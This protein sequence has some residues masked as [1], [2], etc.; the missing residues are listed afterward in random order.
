MTST[1]QGRAPLRVGVVGL[2]GAGSGMTSRFARHPWFTLAAAA[3]IDEVLLGRFRVDFPGVPAYANAEGV[4]PQGDLDLVYIA[5]PNRFHAEHACMALSAGKHVLVEKPMTFTLHDADAMIEA[6]DREREAARRQRQAQLRAPRREGRR[7]R[8]VRGAWQV[9]HAPQ[10][11]VRRLAL[12]SAHRGGAHAGVGRR[13]PMAA[14]SSPTGHLPRDRRRPDSQRQGQRRRLGPVAARQ[15][16]VHRLR[17]RSRAAR[18]AQPSTAGTTTTRAASSS[19]ER[20]MTTTA[21]TARPAANSP[22]MRTAPRG[23]RR[24]REPNGTAATA[25]R[26]PG[27]RWGTGSRRPAARPAAVG[28]STAR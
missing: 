9:P 3:D 15:R 11:A 16:G 10:L 21:G 23:K 26:F 12:P 14:G 6:A 22:A 20:S 24:R 17:G 28:C 1:Q 13:H 18:S 4:C 2:G 25:V 8:P 5:T 7:V 27:A 19:S